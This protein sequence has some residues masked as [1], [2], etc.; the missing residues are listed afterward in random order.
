MSYNN[1]VFFIKWFMKKKDDNQSSM[2]RASDCLE[3]KVSSI[4]L[5]K[6]LS[7]H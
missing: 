6:H 1:I 3:N 5:M 7:E 2:F 4:K